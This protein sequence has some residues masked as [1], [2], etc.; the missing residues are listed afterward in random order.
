[1]GERAKGRW[2]RYG[3]LVALNVLALSAGAFFA[4]EHYIEQRRPSTL[5]YAPHPL[6]RQVLLANQHY[7]RG[8]VRFEIGPHHMRGPEPSRPKPAGV[9]RIHVL[10]GSAVFDHLSPGLSWPERLGPGLGARF[11]SH[12]A[13]VPGFSSRETLSFYFDRVRRYAPDVVVLYQGWN[14]VKYVRDFHESGVDVD[15]H[16]GYRTH[17]FASF[18]FLTADRPRRN[19]L[20]LERMWTDRMQ[21]ELQENAST[22]E[23]PKAVI[24]SSA[25][26]AAGEGVGYFRRNVA[27]FVDLAKNDGALPVL[28]AQGTLAVAGLDP[29]LQKRIA[30]Q[31]TALTPGELLAVNEAMVGALRS[32]AESRRVPFV[33]FRAAVNGR[34]DLFSDHVHLTPK[35]SEVVAAELVAALRPILEA[36]L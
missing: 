26:W 11:E 6:H 22:S 9:T 24:T 10:G 14:D 25:A 19:V 30:Y 27:A 32:V 20:A 34:P 1:M 5:V 35:G 23:A 17:F 8:G 15:K 31:W 16:Y 3:V 18:D 2:R 12:N 4:S 36:R 33:D 7:T 28:V 13:G 21:S 29:A